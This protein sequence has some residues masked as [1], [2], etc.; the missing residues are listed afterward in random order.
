MDKKVE[1]KG[2]DK[3]LAEKE[4][5]KPTTVAK[6]ERSTK[7]RKRKSSGGSS[8]SESSSSSRRSSGHRKGSSSK[9]SSSSNG[10]SSDSS[11]SSSSDDDESSGGE[12]EES[13]EGEP[14][15]DLTQPHKRQKR[16][17]STDSEDEEKERERGEKKEEGTFKHNGLI[18][19]NGNGNVNGGNFGD[20]FLGSDGDMQHEGTSITKILSKQ[21]N[22]ILD[23]LTVPSYT[24]LVY[25][26][27]MK[28]H[29]MR[30]EFHL[31]QPQRISTIFHHLR[32]CG[33]TKKC[34]LCPTRKATS[35]EILLGHT[36]KHYKELIATKTMNNEQLNQMETLLNSIFLNQSSA[37]CGLLACGSVI[38]LVE[39]VVAGDF[40]NGLAIVRP[41]GH[42]AEPDHAMGFCLFNSVGVAA[43]VAQKRLGVKRIMIVDWD[44]HFGNGTYSMFASDPDVL[45]FSIHRYDDGLFYPH[46][47]DA[48]AESSG[49]GEGKGRT[50]NIPWPQGKMRDADYIYAFQRVLLPIASEFDPDL[51]LVLAGFDAADGDPIGECDLSSDCFAHMTHMLKSFANGKIVLVLEGGYNLE[52]IAKASAACASVL[53]GNEPNRLSSMVPSEVALQ[54]IH[55]VCQIQSKFWN[56]IRP[57]FVNPYDN[58]QLIQSQEAS[59]RRKLELKVHIKYLSTVVG[60]YLADVLSKANFKNLTKNSKDIVLRPNRVF[61]SP[62]FHESGSD[63]LLIFHNSGIVRYTSFEIDNHFPAQGA[64]LTQTVIPFV[65]TITTKE[66]EYG[67]MLFNVD[68]EDNEDNEEE[69]PIDK[70]INCLW[71]DHISKSQAKK[72]FI[73]GV[74][75]SLE[76]IKYIIDQKPDERIKG[77]VILLGSEPIPIVKPECAD[78]FYDVI[79]QKCDVI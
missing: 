16:S 41:P 48:S 14:K 57:S 43:K 54:T 68:S 35:D 31:E 59:M 62:K 36:E 67:A 6:K 72:F 37:D 29:S 19:E 7:K 28:K 65:N 53:L 39:K 20:G 50:V 51:I 34:I 30:N 77:I 47:K 22:A 79:F 52:S 40:R 11:S 9:T 26:Q 38:S 17:P 49:E 64:L 78:W 44:I 3:I 56:S 63:L 2:K 24:G 13:K 12:N 27:D 18:M 45:Y 46:S 66:K 55:I 74:P 25:D 70:M 58:A 60:F 75:E 33:I 8:D 1:V 23:V 4:K 71:E 21:A 69:I 42:H 73:I 32:K 5:A 76:Y 10:S 15:E 61:L